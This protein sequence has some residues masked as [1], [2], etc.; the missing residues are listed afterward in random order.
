MALPKGLKLAPLAAVHDV[1]Y[2]SDDPIS[3]EGHQTG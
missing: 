3:H 2:S 1:Q